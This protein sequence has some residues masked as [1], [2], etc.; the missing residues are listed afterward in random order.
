MTQ[1]YQVLLA[2]DGFAYHGWQ[3]QING[4]SVQEVIEKAFEKIH[5]QKTSITASG[6]TD[7]GVHATGQVFHFDADGKISE[8]G[9][10]Q[11]LNTILPKDIRVL[12]V[13]K[14]SAEFHARFSARE[15]RYD[16]V[17]T[18]KKN[19]PFSY[20]YKTKVRDNIDVDVMRKASRIFLGKHDFT[21]FT[22]AKIPENKPRVKEI[23][24]IV[25]TEE[26][27]DIRIRF[28]ADGF[29]RCQVRM[30]SAVLIRAGEGKLTEKQI[31]AM[32]DARDKEAVRFN[33]PS[34]GL[35]LVKVTYDPEFA[36]SDDSET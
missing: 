28:E 21:S 26:G 17:L 9:Y 4:L 23:R 31:Q 20:R 16:Y 3:K 13:K 10:E 15:K 12:K 1:R 32:L 24:N 19:D 5:K 30:M 34:E 29:L 36:I 14:V 11:A 6:R 33:A 25:I 27:Q 35:Y 22:H 18:R 8:Y 2:Y 7:A